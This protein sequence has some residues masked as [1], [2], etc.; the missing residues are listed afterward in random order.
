MVH[1]ICKSKWL[2]HD[3]I[4]WYCT[5]QLCEFNG[6]ED[7]N[8]EAILQKSHPLSECLVMKDLTDKIISK[9]SKPKEKQFL[10]M[11]WSMKEKLKTL[12]AMLYSKYFRDLICS[13]DFQFDMGLVWD[14]YVWTKVKYFTAELNYHLKLSNATLKTTGLKQEKT[15]DINIDNPLNKCKFYCFDHVLQLNSVAYLWIFQAEATHVII[16]QAE[17]KSSVHERKAALCRKRVSIRTV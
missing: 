14:Y 7:E 3:L 15:I 9:E 10:H 12:K 6:T 8:R 2:I 16:Y 17:S 4:I 11:Y 13:N 5:K 1:G